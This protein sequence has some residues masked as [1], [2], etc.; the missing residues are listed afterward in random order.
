MRVESRLP[1][2]GI[3]LIRIT[4]IPVLLCFILAACGGGGDGGGS[5]NDF[6]ELLPRDA[7]GMVYVNTAQ[8]MEDDDLR[9]LHREVAYEWASAEFSSDYGIRLRDTSYVAFAEV[10]NDNI[11]ALGGLEVDDRDDLRDELDDYDYDE[12][13]IRGVE[14][15]VNTSAYLEAFAFL[16][17]GSV[18]IA[19]YED[20]MDD[21]LRRRERGGS[22]LQEEAGGLVSSLSSGAV[23]VVTPYCGQVYRS[24]TD[25]CAFFGFSVE[26][27]GSLDFKM[28]LVWEFEYVDEAEDLFDEL[29][30]DLEEEDALIDSDCDYARADQSESRVTLEI[31]CDM[32][33]IANIA[34]IDF[35]F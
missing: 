16:P 15:W 5:V 22:S 20:L 13:E 31:T 21:V 32:E 35:N 2:C 19:E 10:D 24:G 4:L 25:D 28:K 12:D 8:I 1:R 9:G 30:A 33:E 11:Y 18:L 6:M 3:G 7:E 23:M 26:K 17:N 14:V 27:E 34:E 29:E